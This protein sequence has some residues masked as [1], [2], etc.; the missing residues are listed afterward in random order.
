MTTSFLHVCMSGG[1]TLALPSSQ[2]LFFSQNEIHGH[3]SLT[4]IYSSSLIN[5]PDFCTLP[6][7]PY[8]IKVQTQYTFYYPFLRNLGG[9]VDS[10]SAILASFLSVIP[11]ASV[12]YFPNLL[13]TWV[14]E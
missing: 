11:S 12:K 13:A 14:P 3:F 8:N 10:L 7:I 9:D 6:C 2:S 1:Y 4:T 5:S